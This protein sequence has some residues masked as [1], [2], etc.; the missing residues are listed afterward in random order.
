M[1]GSGLVPQWDAIK[2]DGA[3]TGA[4]ASTHKV[5][6]N[7]TV[8]RKRRR[9]SVYGIAVLYMHRCSMYGIV[10]HRME[11]PF[12]TWNCSVN[13]VAVFHAATPFHK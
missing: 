2:D 13:S 8:G 3:R 12:Y 7:A 11:S 5:A 9:R 6:P 10:V 1:E 4:V